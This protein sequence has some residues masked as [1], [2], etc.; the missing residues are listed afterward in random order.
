FP[1]DTD[2]RFDCALPSQVV[3]TNTCFIDNFYVGQPPNRTVSLIGLGQIRKADRRN[4]IIT[5]G[6][7]GR[8]D[9]EIVQPW[10]KFLHKSVTC[11]HPSNGNG[12]KES[13]LSSRLEVF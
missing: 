10:R 1:F 6:P 3:S 12:G 8:P 7:I 5:Y 9:F 2:V 4:P 11:G 13:V